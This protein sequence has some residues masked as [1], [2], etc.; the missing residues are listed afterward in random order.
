MAHGFFRGEK[1]RHFSPDAAG[2]ARDTGESTGNF[3]L[4][5]PLGD[6]E[7]SRAA[8]LAEPP[9]PTGLVLSILT[10]RPGELKKGAGQTARMGQSQEEDRT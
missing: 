6:R 10:T 4:L 5:L 3:C 7:V 1:N 2:F 9:Y 8:H